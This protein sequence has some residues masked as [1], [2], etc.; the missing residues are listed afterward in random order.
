[1]AKRKSLE[2]E[3]STPDKPV[4]DLAKENAALRRQLSEALEQQAATADVLK[5]I[6]HST[7]DLQAVLDVL[8]E[9]ATR[10]CSAPHGNFSI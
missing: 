5:V 2:H 3:G 4:V 1:M 9:S 6:R 7:F 8:V 10:L